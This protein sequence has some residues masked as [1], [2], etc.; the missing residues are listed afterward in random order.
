MDV[1]RLNE[2]I[3]EMNWKPIQE[4]FDMEIKQEVIDLISNS[5]QLNQNMLIEAQ[6]KIEAYRYFMELPRI[7]SEKAR[8][9][10]VKQSTTRR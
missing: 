7:I 9:Q 3:R 4:F 2:I 6:A 10:D 1:N 8:L 5:Q